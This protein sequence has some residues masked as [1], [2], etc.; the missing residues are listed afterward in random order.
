MLDGLIHTDDR[1]AMKSTTK[2]M[3]LEKETEGKVFNS[4][5]ENLSFLL[6]CLKTGEI[7]VM[8]EILVVT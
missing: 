4:F 2:Q 1:I 7:I 5:A 3:N 6:H 8:E